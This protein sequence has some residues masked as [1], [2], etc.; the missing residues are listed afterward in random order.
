M[1]AQG[2]VTGANVDGD[3][4]RS[5]TNRARRQL[6][7]GQVDRQRGRPGDR[8]EAG[9]RGSAAISLQTIRPSAAC[10]GASAASAASVDRAASAASV[11]AFSGKL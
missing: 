3:A 8:R 5:L 1:L 7:R 10:R 4:H 9:M 6:S 11:A 2:L